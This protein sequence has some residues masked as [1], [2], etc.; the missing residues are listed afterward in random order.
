MNVKIKLITIGLLIFISIESYS[1]NLYTNPIVIPPS[2]LA[3]TFQQSDFSKVNL[4]NGLPLVNIPIY[5]LELGSCKFPISIN[6]NYNGFKVEEVSSWL[7]LGWNI[8]AG[9]MI[10]HIVR[11]KADEGVDGYDMVKELL[12]IPDPINEPI[13]YNNF[14]S[15]LSVDAKRKFADGIYDGIPDEYVIKANNISG[16]ILKLSN[17]GFATIPYKPY[18]ISGT[19]NS[20]SIYD[21]TGNLYKFGQLDGESNNNGLE[22][23]S[24]QYQNEYIDLPE[25]QSYT[26]NWFLR[27][28]VTTTGDKIDFNYVPESIERLPIK[29]ET[30]FIQNSIYSNCPM[31]YQLHGTTSFGTTSSWK[32]SSIECRKCSIYFVSN[33][34]R[35][36]IIPGSNSTSLDYIEIKDAKGKLIKKLV[37]EYDYLGDVT[38]YD[39]CR[40]ILKKITEIGSNTLLQAPPYEFSYES[41]PTVPS[42]SSYSQD[43]WGFYNGKSNSTLIPAIIHNS[44]NNDFFKYSADRNPDPSY[45]KLGLLKSITLPTNGVISYFYE[46]NEYGFINNNKNPSEMIPLLKNTTTASIYHATNVFSIEVPLTINTAQTVNIDYSFNNYGYPNEPGEVSLIDNTGCVIFTKT[47]VNLSGTE[48]KV[49]ATGNYKL[50]ASVDGVGYSAKISVEKTDYKTNEQGELVYSKNLLTGGFR[51]KKITQFD[52]INHQNDIISNYTYTMNDEADRSSG[53]LINEPSYEY[54]IKQ[55]EIIFVSGIPESDQFCLYVARTGTSSR[56][57]FGDDGH[58]GY[59][60]VLESKGLNGENGSTLTNFT[61]SYEYPDNSSPKM[62][63]ISKGFRRGEVKKITKFNSFGQ[64]IY[65]SENIYN[66]PSN[67][68]NRSGIAGIFLVEYFENNYQDFLDRFKSPYFGIIESNWSYL[69]ESKDIFYYNNEPVETDI[70]YFYENPV[71]TQLT[72]TEEHNSKG[73]LI[74]TKFFY[75]SD[76]PSNIQTDNATMNLLIQ[77]NMQVKLKIEKSIHQNIEGQIVNYGSNL[78][79][80]SLYIMQDNAYQPIIRYDS[81]DSYGNILQLHQESNINSSFFWGYK[82]LYPVVKVENISSTDLNTAVNTAT[83][84]DLETLLENIGDLTNDIQKNQWKTFNTALRN[85]ASLSKSQVTTYTYLPLIG[86]TSQTDPNG[87][88]TYYEYDGLGRLK[89]VKDHKGNILKQ[90]QYHYQNQP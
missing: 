90:T 16:S 30:Q 59:R 4:Y 65:T 52:G 1:Q 11:G 8:N 31:L 71:H 35:K 21:E 9:G 75:P 7:G 29:N 36:D 64:T 27:E 66:D 46:P 43:S 19:Y 15:N 37:F 22:H 34:L 40:L 5:N 17:G 62:Q 57:V 14:M 47:G 51:I 54:N 88:T 83:G 38:K 55:A 60:Y 50:K 10:S 33:S 44:T 76:N 58:I 25:E 77:K 23:S 84:G 85:N 41:L 39:Q 67:S 87:I 72:K 80:S 82:N 74:E 73:E 70:K 18:K 63:T 26:S 89:N 81:Y 86:M 68:P 78:L 53:V 49:L 56:S 13:L 20:W 42:Y 6:Y 32:L 28:I 48:K 61:T 2:P 79:P 12:N 45:S 24:T 69:T 3:S